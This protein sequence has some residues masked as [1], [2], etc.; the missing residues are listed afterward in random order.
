MFTKLFAAAPVTPPDNAVGPDATDKDPAPLPTSAAS[1][2]A[3]TVAEALIA[4]TI[5][6][7]VFCA[8]CATPAETPSAMVIAVPL[9][10]TARP[11]VPPGT[12]TW[13]VMLFPAAPAS[14]A[15]ITKAEVPDPRARLAEAY[16][17]RSTENHGFS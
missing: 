17:D 6:V 13:T 1:T 4:A 15:V 2:S 14:R 3:E 9:T 7:A 16:P 5:N 11:D 12:V 8:A 10:D